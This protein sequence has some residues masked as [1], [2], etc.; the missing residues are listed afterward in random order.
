M[1]EYRSL[2]LAESLLHSKLG[3]IFIFDSSGRLLRWNENLATLLREAAAM[4]FKEC[5]TV[6]FVLSLDSGTDFPAEVFSKG[7][8]LIERPRPGCRQGDA[9]DRIVAWVLH[10]ILGT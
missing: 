1:P 6:T 9:H 7:T 3:F 10:H 4:G 2:P 5:A 8:I